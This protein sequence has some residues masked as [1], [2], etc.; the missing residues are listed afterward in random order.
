M[1]IH[2]RADFRIATALDQAK[3]TQSR[4]EDCMEIQPSPRRTDLVLTVDERAKGAS[5]K[6]PFR[7]L[8]SERPLH[9]DCEDRFFCTF[10]ILLRGSAWQSASMRGKSP[11]MKNPSLRSS[12]FVFWE[13]LKTLGPRTQRTPISSCGNAVPVGL[14]SLGALI[15]KAKCP[16]P[17][18]KYCEKESEDVL[19][20][21]VGQGISCCSTAHLG[22]P[23]GASPVTAAS[24]HAARPPRRACMPERPCA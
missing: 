24:T 5:A 22:G 10:P 2:I 23:S 7:S 20:G 1:L 4:R 8:R 11:A 19:L 12:S 9:I 15:M 14:N 16:K 3:E 18:Q 6:F 21:E 13:P 17:R